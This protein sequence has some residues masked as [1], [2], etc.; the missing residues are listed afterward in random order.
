LS[1]PVRTV[2]RALDIIL[3]FNKKNSTLSLTEITR[4]IGVS[5]STAHRMVRTLEDKR[6]LF[7]NPNTRKYHLGFRFLE[8][9]SEGFDDL[10]Q[11]W[12]LPYLQDLVE[13]SGET[14]D[15]AILDGDN[16]IFLQ[17]VES[18]QRVKLTARKGQSLPAY[19]T[20]S[21]K[22]FLA[23]LPK[24]AVEQIV[25]SNEG[26]CSANKPLKRKSLV[27]D[28]EATLSR[29]FAI[30]E[31]EYEKDINAVAAPIL[32]MDGYPVMTIALAGPSIRFSRERMMELGRTIQNEINH[33]R[34]EISLTALPP[35]MP[36]KS[37]WPEKRMG[38]D[39]MDFQ[40][41]TRKE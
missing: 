5:K 28:L 17:V 32:S 35:S 26:R 15:L 11:H 16:V 19:C 14:A 2:D 23:Y 30:S 3:C 18:N 10:D 41:S 24:D 20:A 38:E 36:R 1:E 25:N 6:F 34:R 9:A 39:L 40:D 29:G 7:R 27:K 37:I 22:A 31:E 33:I 12:V 8:I 21:G 4:Q 13:K